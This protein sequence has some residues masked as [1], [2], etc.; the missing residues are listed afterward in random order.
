MVDRRPV[1]QILLAKHLI[2]SRGALKIAVLC[3]NMEIYFTS[4]YKSSVWDNVDAYNSKLLRCII[5]YCTSALFSIPC[6]S[7]ARWIA[8][9]RQVELLISNHI[10]IRRIT[11]PILGDSWNAIYK[12]SVHRYV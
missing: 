12:S 6:S 7:P 4:V 2:T 8:Y 5:G 9:L 1:N 10:M 11:E 3:I